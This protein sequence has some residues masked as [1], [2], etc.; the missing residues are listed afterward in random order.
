MWAQRRDHT[1]TLRRWPSVSPRKRPQRK[2]STL[3]FLQ[4]V[5]CIILSFML[6]VQ[7]PAL[8]ILLSSAGTPKILALRGGSNITECLTTNGDQDM[9]SWVRIYNAPLT[10]PPEE[11]SDPP[12]RNFVLLYSSLAFLPGPQ[13][14]PIPSQPLPLWKAQRRTNSSVSCLASLL[15]TCMLSP[16][17][18]NP[19]LQNGFY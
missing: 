4:T 19:L 11:I 12:D 18:W 5:A 3:L 6:T 1:R 13:W 9:S 16:A 2:S 17:L 14:C 15:P 10:D 7:G 8:C